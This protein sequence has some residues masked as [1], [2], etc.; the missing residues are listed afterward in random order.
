VFHA[1]RCFGRTRRSSPLPVSR[2]FSCNSG[3]RPLQGST[4]IGP[5]SQQF[6]DRLRT[7]GRSLIVPGA[8]AQFPPITPARNGGPEFCPARRVGGHT[9]PIALTSAQR[10][11][12]TLHDSKALVAKELPGRCCRPDAPFPGC[13]CCLDRPQKIARLVHVS[14]RAA[15]FGVRQA[16]CM[17]LAVEQDEPRRPVHIGPDGLHGTPA[18]P[19]TLLEHVESTRPLRRTDLFPPG[20]DRAGRDNCASPFCCGKN[21]KDQNQKS[22]FSLHVSTI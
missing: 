2:I 22:S 11:S 20:G 15:D 16:A 3:L 5:R 17:P 7:K 1:V 10:A 21:L 18:L 9:Q 12:V 13:A 6:E 4:P 19:C 8:R 14:K